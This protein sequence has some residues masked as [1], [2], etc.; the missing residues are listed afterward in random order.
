MRPACLSVRALVCILPTGNRS[1]EREVL[2]V[3]SIPIAILPSCQDVNYRLDPHE[4]GLVMRLLSESVL[5]DCAYICTVTM[6][7]SGHS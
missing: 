2:L 4:Q 3:R 7:F 5:T 1:E 6:A